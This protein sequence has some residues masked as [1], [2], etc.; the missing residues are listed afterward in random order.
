MR[1]T[2]TS[3][4]S[5]TILSLFHLIPNWFVESVHITQISSSCFILLD[6]QLMLVC[7]HKSKVPEASKERRFTFQTSVLTVMLEWLRSGADPGQSDHREGGKWELNDNDY[8]L[9]HRWGLRKIALRLVSLLFSTY[10]PLS[11]FIL[12]I[13]FILWLFLSH[14]IAII[15]W[16]AF[17]I[18][19]FLNPEQSSLPQYILS[20]VYHPS[21]S[22]LL[23]STSSLCQTYSPFLSS[24]EQIITLRENSQTGQ[25]RI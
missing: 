18:L 19:F 8:I 25:K 6:E 12:D 4:N 16:L 24:S 23:S 2:V 15:C 20:T 13:L 14:V 9:N 11:S 21:N 17:F 22:Q 1:Y 7:I 5:K 10:I 3:M